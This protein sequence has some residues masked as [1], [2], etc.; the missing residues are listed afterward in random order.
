[1]KHYIVRILAVG[2]IFGALFSST[3]SMANAEEKISFSELQRWAVLWGPTIGEILTTVTIGF[4]VLVALWLRIFPWIIGFF[5]KRLDIE[6]FNKGAFGDS[7]QG[8]E[9]LVGES[10]NRLETEGGRQRVHLHRS[11]LY[12]TLSSG[13]SPRKL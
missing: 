8:L 10:L 2:F 1:M 6:D 5:F 4:L 13:L 9:V 12:Q 3:I 7:V 11:T